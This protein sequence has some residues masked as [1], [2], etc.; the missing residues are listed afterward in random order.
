MNWELLMQRLNWL[1]TNWNLL[2]TNSL[3]IFQLPEQ[4]AGNKD[5]AV[6]NYTAL[7]T[8]KFPLGQFISDFYAA[9]NRILTRGTIDRT[10]DTFTFNLGFSWLINGIEYANT[11]AVAI[12][13]E[14][15]DEGFKRIDI[16][17]VDTDG[18]IRKIIGMQSNT[19][20]QTPEPEPNTVLLTTFYIFGDEITNPTDGLMYKQD[21]PFEDSHDFSLPAGAKAI[22]VHV[23]RAGLLANEWSQTDN[24]VTISGSYE[25]DADS[26]ISIFGTY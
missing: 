19:V 12:E 21:F 18:E 13:I 1:T 16:V 5:V 23:S 3:K 24:I 20:A 11:E 2:V 26:I 9:F 8:E 17:V 10:D 22:V 15:A 4:S 6:W 25:I 7:R 14:P